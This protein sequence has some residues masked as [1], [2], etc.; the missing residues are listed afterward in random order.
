MTIQYPDHWRGTVVPWL[1]I[2]LFVR[3]YV[4]HGRSLMMLMGDID[5]FQ[6]AAF[7]NGIEFC[8]CC[9]DATDG[10]GAEFLEFVRSR[11]G[12]PAGGW[13]KKFLAEANGDHLS[14][15]QRFLDYAYEFAQTRRS[16]NT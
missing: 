10:E 14:A 5:V 15:I 6:F 1:D 9:S 4:Q 13:A 7:V 12:A 16:D 2:I 11:E 3:E 8:R